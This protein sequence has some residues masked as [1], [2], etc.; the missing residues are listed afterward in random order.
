MIIDAHTHLWEREWLSESFWKGLASLIHHMI[1]SMKLEEIWEN[2]MPTLWHAPPEELLVEMDEAGIEKAVIL[3]LD[4]GLR[5]GEPKVSVEE[6]NRLF[7]EIAKNYP[8][9]FIAFVGVDPRRKNA[10]ELLEKGLGKWE[11]RG[12][13]LHPTSGF[14]PNDPICYPLYRKCEEYG[15]PVLIHTGTELPPLLSRFARPVYV[16][17]VAAD[18]PELKIIMAHMGFGW[19]E[20]AM[21]VAMMKPNVYMDTAA[22]G[23]YCE[24]SVYFYRVLR[25][26][27]DMVGSDRI[28]FGS[29]WPLTPKPLL[30]EAQW[31]DKFRN[32]PPQVK[33]AGI[34]FT[35][36]EIEAI[37]GRNAARVLG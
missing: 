32:P 22:W 7:A 36:E 23:N 8:D 27:C 37:L 24:P 18:F 28:L 26:I 9:R 14:F 31:V 5:T 13:K 1:P 12:L 25:T 21:F 29:D 4:W 6:L 15:A 34:E 16:D 35:S 30:S 2:V 17:D 3:P 10:V 19:W 20:E 11:M 33:A